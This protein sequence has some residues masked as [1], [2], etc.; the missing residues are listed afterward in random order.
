MRSDHVWLKIVADGKTY[1]RTLGALS[2][3][4]DRGLPAVSGKRLHVLAARAA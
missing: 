2:L 4:E 3:P 1:Y